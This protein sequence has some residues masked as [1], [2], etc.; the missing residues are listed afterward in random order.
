M[1]KQQMSNDKKFESAPPGTYGAVCTRVIDLGTQPVQWEG[2]TKHQRKVSIQWELDENMPD[3]RPF[4]I[5]RKF[6][7][8]MHEKAALRI[9]LKGWRGR[10]FTNDELNGFNPVKLIGVPC[11]LSLVANGDFVNV[12][13]ASKL[14][15]GMTPLTP[16]NPTVY[17]SL[18]DFDQKIYDS[19]GNRMKED[20]SNSPEFIALKGNQTK[21]EGGHG[22][23]D[24]KDDIP[25][26]DLAF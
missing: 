14:P 25:G 15:K 26:E 9:F 23:E 20:I 6:T 7:V 3:G 24:M 12:A 5:N 19:L 13:S 11:M 2:E 17:F 1:W 4:V 16:K 8:S 10:D 22:F 18:D 21:V